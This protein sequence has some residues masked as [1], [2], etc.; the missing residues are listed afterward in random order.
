MNKLLILFISIFLLANLISAACEENQIDINIAPAEDL[1]KINYIAEKRAEQMIT[2]RPFSSVDDMIR[3]VGIGEVHLEAIKSQGLACVNDKKDEVEKDEVEQESNEED[4]V[5]DINKN[6]LF[7]EDNRSKK[8]EKQNELPVINLT[9]QSIKIEKNKENTGKN[10]AML[11]F[12]IFCILLVFLFILRKNK[13]K[14]E[15][16]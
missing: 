6:G 3:I 4:L 11:G 7:V 8:S 14:N 12:I 2:L 13:L 15:F 9:P 16:S 10:Y 1:V 5:E